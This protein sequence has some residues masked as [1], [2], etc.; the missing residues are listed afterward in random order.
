MGPEGD[1]VKG[2]RA[3]A[4]AAACLALLVETLGVAGWWG[5][6][7][8]VSALERREEG[9]ATRLAA[10][11][12]LA[13]PAGVWWTRRLA[14]SELDGQPRAAVAAALEATGRRLLR[15]LPTDPEGPTKLAQAAL[16]RGE[17]RRADRWAGEAVR[18][19][20]TSPY[21]LRLRAYVARELGEYSR[22]LDLLAD[23]AAVAPGWDRPRVEVLPG[24][25]VWVRLEG[26]RRRA[27]LYP[28][29]AVD[30]TLQLARE[31]RSLGREEEARGLVAGLG[32]PGA[33]LELARWAAEEGR[34]GDVLAE[35]GSVTGSASAPRRL[36]GAAWALV[37]RARA[38]LGDQDGALEAAERAL[39]LEPRSPQPYLALADMAERR[40]DIELALEH[41]RRAWGVAPTDTGVLVRVA[42]LAELAGRDA[43]ARLALRRAVELEPD[44]P[45]LRVRLV[46]LLLRQGRIV[47]A[48]MT[49][50]DALDRFPTDPSLLRLAATLGSG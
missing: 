46:R 17:T 28:R 1:A 36:R 41:A 42:R 16:L 18:R 8:T 20:P 24:D 47:D 13:T 11:P 29:L 50:S 38:A 2:W 33:A 3:A 49:L 21:L 4:T 48:A 23:A 40:G 19:W 14:G 35:A 12:L 39:R 27:R 25:R 30:T 7:G 44:R 26:L 6:R 15:W 43:D 45:E 10:S 32:G 34:W 37:S 5:W 31:L 22:C 9:A